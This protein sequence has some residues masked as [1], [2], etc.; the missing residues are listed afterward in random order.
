MKAKLTLATIGLVAIVLLAI[1]GCSSTGAALKCPDLASRKAHIPLFAKASKPAHHTKPDNTVTASTATAVAPAQ[2]KVAVKSMKPN[3]LTAAI[4][5]DLPFK[6]KVPKWG[7]QFND[8][9]ID[10]VNTFLGKYSNNHVAITKNAKGKVFMS[11]TSAKEFIKLTKQLAEMKKHPPIDDHVGD[12]LALVGFICGIVA[13][14]LCVVPY[15]D[16]ISIFPAGP[17]GVV[18]GI[19]GLHSERH[20]KA[21]IGI[22]LGAIGFTLGIVFFILWSVVFLP[23][24]IL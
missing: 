23:G 2:D 6:I 16:F 1:S 10:K 8:E 15:V 7:G 12:I 18:L 3:Q 19:L 5:G 22:I 11:A 21:L 14:G 4:K 9:E 20:T 24:I 13:I 17:A